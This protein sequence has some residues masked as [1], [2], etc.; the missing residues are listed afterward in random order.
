MFIL[1]GLNSNNLINKRIIIFE[2]HKLINLILIKI[3]L[4]I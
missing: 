1:M 4:G 2:D 3:K